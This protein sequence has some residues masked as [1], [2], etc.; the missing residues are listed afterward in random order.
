M[1]RENVYFDAVNS[2]NLQLLRGAHPPSDTPLRRTSATISALRADTHHPQKYPRAATVLQI[3][4][5]NSSLFH[6]L[7]G[8]NNT[9]LLL[10]LSL[11]QYA[12]DYHPH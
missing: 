5:E 9:Y 1:M 12:M 4:Q 6:I 7:G 11:D 2:K 10:Q 3:R 8:G